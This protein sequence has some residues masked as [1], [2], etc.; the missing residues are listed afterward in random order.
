[1]PEMDGFETAEEIR[2]SDTD[3]S[4]VF[5]TSYYTITNAGKGFE[6]AAE[7]FL[8]KP[9]KIFPYSHK[10]NT[11]FSTALI[12]PLNSAIFFPFSRVFRHIFFFIYMEYFIRWKKEKYA[13]FTHRLFYAIL[14]RNFTGFIHNQGGNAA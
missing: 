2:K 3:V 14:S 4:I 11:A 9:T 7:D 13:S 10:N 6:V 12:S 5:C 8:S 1:M